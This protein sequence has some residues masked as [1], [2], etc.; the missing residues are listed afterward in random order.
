MAHDKLNMGNFI[1]GGI[2]LW[3]I[4]K[5]FIEIIYHFTKLMKVTSVTHT[6]YLRLSHG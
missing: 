2:Q 6:S 5:I 3:R 4:Q 1:L